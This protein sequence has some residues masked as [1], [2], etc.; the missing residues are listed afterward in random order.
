MLILQRPKVFAFAWGFGGVE[1]GVSVVM[2]LSMVWFMAC[3]LPWCRV[4]CACCRGVSVDV[5]QGMVCLL[6]WCGVGSV[7]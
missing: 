4:W 5:V 6:L 3:L 1:C 2:V 7:C